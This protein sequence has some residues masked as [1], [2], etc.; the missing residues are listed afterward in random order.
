MFEAESDFRAEFPNKI[1][2]DQKEMTFALEWLNRSKRKGRDIHFGLSGGDLSKIDPD[3][4]FLA[5]LFANTV[6]MLPSEAFIE[7]YV[8][9]RGGGII[10][11]ARDLGASF[12]FIKEADG[13]GLFGR[14]FKYHT[15]INHFDGRCERGPTF[16]RFSLAVTSI[17]NIY[18][19]AKDFVRRPGPR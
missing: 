8:T 6:G 18:A 13:R 15:L 5:S 11:E 19:A 16:K 10:I 12:V 3:T 2:F 1:G 9:A 14:R 4:K 17:A 7:F